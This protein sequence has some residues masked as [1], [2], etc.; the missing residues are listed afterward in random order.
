MVCRLAVCVALL[1]L[2]PPAFGQPESEPPPAGSLAEILAQADQMPPPRRLG[3]RSRVRQSAA[4]VVPTLV[5][6]E[7]EHD[8]LRAMAGWRGVA[9]YPVL[10]DDGTL[11]AAAGIARFA[12]MFEPKFV[13]RWSSG[14]ADFAGPAEVRAAILKTVQVVYSAEEG[15]GLSPALL[16]PLERT[17]LSVDGVVVV[18]PRDDAWVGGVALAMGRIQGIGF[19]SKIGGVNGTLQ[20]DQL[21]A[22]RSEITGAIETLGLEWRGVGSGVD[23]VTLAM[24]TSSKVAAPDAPRIE[25]REARLALTDAIVREGAF[26][27]PRWA[28]AGLLFGSPRE[29]LERAMGSLFAVHETAWIFDGYPN[30]QPW[31]L[32]SGL[33]AA[34]ELRKVELESEVIGGGTGSIDQWRRSAPTFDAGL[35]LINTKGT[36]GYFETQSGAGRPGDAPLLKKPASAFIVHSWSATTPASAPTIGGRW[37][38]HGAVSY[39]GSVQEPTLNAFVPTPLTARRLL[40]LF[41]FSAAPRIDDAPAG[42]LNYFGDPLLTITP[43]RYWQRLQ[44]EIPLEGTSKVSDEFAAAL[45]ERRYAEGVRGLALLGRDADIVRLVRA[46]LDQNPRAITG[47]V[48]RSAILP[49]Y[50][51]GAWDLFIALYELLDNDSKSSILIADALWHA[52]RAV[53]LN[54]D[55]IRWESALRRGLR[56]GQEPYDAMEAAERAGRRGD[57]PEAAA[58]LDSRRDLARNQQINR[59]FDR[60]I[61]RLRQ[62]ARGSRVP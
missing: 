39:Y 13:L 12:R 4:R 33:E 25:R 44:A 9:R 34:A 11:E 22:M 51:E 41:P 19:V 43:S 28:W 6:V 17:G 53:D 50:H 16:A 5:L 24:N 20:P 38:A 14:E 30:E 52:S 37:L 31:N 49:A 61:E 7:N 3:V 57:G 62:N 8:A 26:N 27:S 36:A 45:R 40:V 60:V 10:I 58:W 54:E 42:R 23:A 56:Q 46:L 1:L 48:A 47:D 55:P 21:S 32:F 2:T 29:S 35:A 59:Q 18:D 15:A